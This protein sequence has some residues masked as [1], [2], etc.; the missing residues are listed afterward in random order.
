MN[1]SKDNKWSLDLSGDWSKIPYSQYDQKNNTLTI[2]SDGA[3]LGKKD[4]VSFTPN[5]IAELRDAILATIEEMGGNTGKPE[6]KILRAIAKEADVYWG[7]IENFIKDEYTTNIAMKI[8]DAFSNMIL[9]PQDTNTQIKTEV[10]F[11]NK[12]MNP[13]VT[14]SVFN[15]WYP[16]MSKLSLY[17]DSIEELDALIK[18][19]QRSYWKDF[20]DN[21][22]DEL[23][24]LNTKETLEADEG[25][26]VLF[27]KKKDKPKLQL[28]HQILPRYMHKLSNSD[29]NK[30]K[31]LIS[32]FFAVY[33]YDL[34]LE[35]NEIQKN[36]DGKSEKTDS[37]ASATVR[38]KYKPRIKHAIQNK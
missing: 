27:D 26:S 21:N 7:A 32:S 9:D 18:A 17:K 31:G 35:I 28:Y 19:T 30:D 12:I 1:K 11:V 36:M 14:S 37:T 25:L 10:D 3:N 22:G 5:E 6:P 16:T 2:N 20:L 8:V 24:L 4:K 13:D 23:E 15:W 34:Y 33:D 38:F 29:K